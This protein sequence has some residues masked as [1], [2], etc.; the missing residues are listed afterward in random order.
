MNKCS[1]KI[2]RRTDKRNVKGENPLILQVIINSRSKKISLKESIDPNHWDDKNS[3]A[4]GKG[5]KLLNVKLDKI[6]SDLQ[7]FCSLKE[8]GGVSV[9]FDL[10]D[11]F[12]K[13][14]KDNDFYQL[15]DEIVIGK[16]LKEAT[17]YKYS[18]LRRRLKSYKSN[19]CTS[20]I[21]YSFVKGFDL[22]LRKLNLKEGGAIYNMHKCLKAIIQEI[23][24]KEMIKFSPYNNFKFQGPKEN[25]DFLDEAEV[26]SLRNFKLDV[27][28]SK[29]YQLTK[30]MFLF[31]CYT[32][33]RFSDCENLLVKNVDL[34][35]SVLSFTQQKTD[36]DI[37]IPFT[38]EARAIL[39]GYMVGKKKDEKIFPF[40]TNQT[41]N[42]KLKD[43]ATLAKINKRVHFHLARHTFASSLVYK[44]NIPLSIVSKLLGH[45]KIASTLV[46]TNS[47]FSLLQ[48]AV[49]DFNYGKKS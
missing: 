30:D 27:D 24:L 33:L 49:K 29:K 23:Y 5:F 40:I 4:I 17:L 38:S 43:L 42:N 25:E 26:V 8:A 1:I 19:I 15:F 28:Q 35:T 36:D 48:N 20:D 46:Y 10:I 13:G 32:G 2:V 31:A 9:T 12:L 6:K 21:N 18:L 34:Q 37:K 47:N 41:V 39:S 22:Y 7:T 14:K 16:G 11:R 3:K 44:F 45:K